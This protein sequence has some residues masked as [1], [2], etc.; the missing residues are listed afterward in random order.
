MKTNDRLQITRVQNGWVISPP[1]EETRMVLSP[2]QVAETQK[3]LLDQVKDL[4][5]ENSEE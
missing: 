3:S 1:A 5:A 4:T 2:M